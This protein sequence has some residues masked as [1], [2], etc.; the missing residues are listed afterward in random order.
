MYF[1]DFWKMYASYCYLSFSLIESEEES[2]Q[3]DESY[4]HPS[5]APSFTK[6]EAVS[7]YTRVQVICT[8]YINLF[9]K[10]QK[11]SLSCGRILR[12]E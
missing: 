2:D 4:L 10:M 11:Q 1:N 6:I 8:L 7:L 3:D 9:L 12:S 5:L